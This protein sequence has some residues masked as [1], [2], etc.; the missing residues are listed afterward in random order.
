MLFKVRALCQKIMNYVI[1][2]L[3]ISV[4]ICQIVISKLLVFKEVSHL[5][6]DWG[7]WSWLGKES[8]FLPLY[9]R[10][11]KIS[12]TTQLTLFF[13]FPMS[14]QNLCLYHHEFY[15]AWCFY[16]NHYLCRPADVFCN[17]KR[18]PTESSFELMPMQVISACTQRY[19]QEPS[20]NAGS[21]RNDLPE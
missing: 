17:G 18:L 10:S 11:N 13:A 20:V 7:M 4:H 2:L 3:I 15:F 14:L 1:M 5:A 12:I 16:S 9:H 21:C 8:A 6:Y 19:P